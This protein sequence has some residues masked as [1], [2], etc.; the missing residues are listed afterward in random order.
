VW[1]RLAAIAE[2]LW[3]PRSVN[4]T[5]MAEPRYDAF[6]CLLNRRGVQAAPARNVDAR[7]APP[8]PGGCYEQ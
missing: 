3:S 2:R 6:R 7:A 8:G 5:A 4:D 1:P